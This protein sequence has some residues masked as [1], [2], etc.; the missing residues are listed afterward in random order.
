[1][2]D[3]K[4]AAPQTIRYAAK[5][6]GSQ[7]VTDYKERH[8]LHPV[9]LPVPLNIHKALSHHALDDGVTMQSLFTLACEKYF[10]S[11]PVTVPPL[12][13]TRRGQEKFKQPTWYADIDLHKR[14]RRLSID[15]G[16]SVQQLIMS[17][18]VDYLK[19]SPRM[20]A[21]EVTT[22]YPPM[23]RGNTEMPAPTGWTYSPAD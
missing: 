7:R 2:T 20:Q 15:T 1:M 6:S 23:A 3:E 8:N 4:K 17:A 16:A 10:G 12:V 19:D 13:A 18:L 22:G 9:V 21:A 14:I 5:T 11:D